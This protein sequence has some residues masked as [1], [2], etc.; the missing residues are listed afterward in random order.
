[1]RPPW[2]QLAAERS[3]ADGNRAVL[4][5]DGGAVYPRIDASLVC[6]GRRAERARRRRERRVRPATERYQA[7][8]PALPA[9]W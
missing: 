1:M 8:T 3:L 7:W 4:R 2:L 9:W 5:S 6:G